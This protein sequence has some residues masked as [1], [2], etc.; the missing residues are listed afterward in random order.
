MAD[1][2]GLKKG[3]L[4]DIEVEDFDPTRTGA[5]VFG[6]DELLLIF[7]S[8]EQ[9]PLVEVAQVCRLCMIRIHCNGVF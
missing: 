9:R 6:V 5:V 7:A 2:I 8:F 1:S 3:K 4:N